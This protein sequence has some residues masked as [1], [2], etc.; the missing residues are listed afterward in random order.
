MPDTPEDVKDS[1][2]APVPLR[3]TRL[4]AGLGRSGF[5]DDTAGH[6]AAAEAVSLVGH[7]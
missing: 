4:G 7:R 6:V 3:S 1:L 2:T 5:P